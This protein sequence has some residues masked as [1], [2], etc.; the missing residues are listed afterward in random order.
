MQEE[1]ELFKYRVL[2]LMRLGHV[3]EEEAISKAAT[4]HSEL[5]VEYIA[6]IRRGGYNLLPVLL[7]R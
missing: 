4:M 5:Y 1:V 6:R 7:R 3:T 2:E